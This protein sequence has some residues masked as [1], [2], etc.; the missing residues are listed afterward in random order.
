[1]ATLT[2]LET[3]T[4]E[5]R[6]DGAPA[7]WWRWLV[8]V[9]AVAA[10][11]AVVLLL[12]RETPRPASPVVQQQTAAR[13]DQNKDLAFRPAPSIA[14]AKKDARDEARVGER[15][16][17][18]EAAKPAAP[19][20]P[21]PAAPTPRAASPAVAAQPAAGAL[22]TKN[23][24]LQPRQAAPPPPTTTGALDKTQA[25]AG[26]NAK[27]AGANADAAASRNLSA[28]QRANELTDAFRVDVVSP[29]GTTKWRIS[30]RTVERSTDGGATWTTAVTVMDGTWTAGAAPSSTTLW[31]VGRK[32]L[33]ERTIDGRTFQRVT[34]PETTDLSAVQATSADTATITTADGRSFGTTDGGKSWVQRL[35]QE[36]PAGS[37]KD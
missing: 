37:F 31:L 35:L 23:A 9:G 7:R 33:V 1:M 32:G 8:P 25:A 3:E 29:D 26:A 21:P 2:R 17:K 24:P 30:S 15:D 10:M 19:A 36:T 13:Q 22:E 18:L 28:L 6:P 14:E 11:L 16:Q 34:F 4:G 5:T 27:A 20:T 12:P